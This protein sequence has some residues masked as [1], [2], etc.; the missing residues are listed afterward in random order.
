MD[1]GQDADRGR[2]E[3]V[4]AA[5][6]EGRTISGAAR[7]AG[8]DRAQLNRWRTGMPD[9]AAAWDEALEIGTDLLEDEALR[10]GLLGVQKPVFHRGKQVG[11]TTTYDDWL[12]TAVLQRRL[13]RRQAKAHRGTDAP[14]AHSPKPLSLVSDGLR[15]EGATPVARRHPRTLH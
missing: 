13:A 2:R 8:I 1:Q 10:R 9:F 12:L 4:L 11:E 3:A 15:P 7:V 14:P 6:R 5:L